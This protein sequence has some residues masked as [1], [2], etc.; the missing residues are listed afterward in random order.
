MRIR[1]DEDLCWQFFEYANCLFNEISRQYL[2]NR[3]VG[4]E[5]TDH[6]A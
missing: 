1:K 5:P 6:G 4:P 2:H 3:E